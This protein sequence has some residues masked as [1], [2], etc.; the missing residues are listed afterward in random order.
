MHYFI[1]VPL[2]FCSLD[3][4]KLGHSPV[5]AFGVKAWK[6]GPNGRGSVFPLVVEIQWMQPLTKLDMSWSIV[7][8]QKDFRTAKSV[9]F[10]PR[11][12]AAEVWAIMQS[13]N[14]RISDEEGIHATLF[15][16]FRRPFDKVT[17]LG[18]HLRTF[19]VRR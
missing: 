13:R 3:G 8:H 18:R 15:L 19:L 12:P 2:I 10:A 17:L 6:D 16:N 7:F 5:R 1:P 9:A 14:C 4:L 11:C